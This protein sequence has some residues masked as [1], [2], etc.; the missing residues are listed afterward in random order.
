MDFRGVVIR[1]SDWGG[2]LAATGA[3]IPVAVCA[4][5]IGLTLGAGVFALRQICISAASTVTM[6]PRWEMGNWQYSCIM[7]T[8]VSTS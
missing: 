1:A 3:E 8:S 2:I 6:K 5:A 7:A 4:A